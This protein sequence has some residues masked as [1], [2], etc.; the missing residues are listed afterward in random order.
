MNKTICVAGASGL[1]G[2]SIVKAALS[3]G[4]SV[5]GTLRDA[6]IKDK[7]DYLYQ[8]E[9]SSVLVVKLAFLAF[10]ISSSSNAN[11]ASAIGLK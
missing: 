5:N 9:G 4:Y 2:S 1:V 6:T 7:V 8:L 11:S 3:R 10:E